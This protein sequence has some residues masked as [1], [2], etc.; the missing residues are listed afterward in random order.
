VKG[1]VP[2][3]MTMSRSL[4]AMPYGPVMLGTAVVALAGG[5]AAFCTVSAHALSGETWNGYS[6][7]VTSAG[8]VVGYFL[9]AVAGGCVVGARVAVIVGA[10][11]DPAGKIDAG[12]YRAYQLAGRAAIAWAL[13]ATAMVFISA[14][15]GSAIGVARLLTSPFVGNA[16]V[17]WEPSR[18][19][20]VVAVCAALAAIASLRWV[21]QCVLL[22][23]ALVGVVAVPVTGNAASGANHDYAT[24]TVIVFWA[25]LATLVGVK[26]AMLNGLGR[27]EVDNAATDRAVRN[28]LN[29]IQVWAGLAVLVYG[30]ILLVLLLP[31]RSVVITEYG[32]MAV[33][34]AVLLIA[35]WVADVARLTRARR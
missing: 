20:I 12:V 22:V 28:R 3:L 6:G 32:R 13:I 16:V 25:V 9:A 35:V 7:L 11:P 1:S 8:D 10:R 26:A 31:A 5:L 30:A 14:A 33:A 24:S 21:G 18:G 15:D 29:L 2:V 17:V 27:G 34:A 23:P 19:W 4:R